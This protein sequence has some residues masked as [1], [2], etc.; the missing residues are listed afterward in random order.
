MI[1]VDGTVKKK[2]LFHELKI[3]EIYWEKKKKCA[4]EIKRSLLWNSTCAKLNEIWTY[5]EWTINGLRY[6]VWNIFYF[7]F[8]FC[9]IW[10][11]LGLRLRNIF[12]KLC[13]SFTRSQDVCENYV[14]GIIFFF[15][16]AVNHECLNQNFVHSQLTLKEQKLFPEAL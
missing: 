16:N 7:L 3:K 1:A 9:W 14:E 15:W 11:G 2:V 8:I 4:G 5:G 13:K 6:K 10:C 12:R